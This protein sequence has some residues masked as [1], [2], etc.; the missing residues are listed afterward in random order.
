MSFKDFPL[1]LKSALIFSILPITIYS[2]YFL[3][4]ELEKAFS[5]FPSSA[6]NTEI[7]PSLSLWKYFAYFM[8]LFCIGA[9][10]GLALKKVFDKY[11]K[12]SSA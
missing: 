10:V 5:Q 9:I 4:I 7:F 2:I 11:L 12:S 6:L 1:W 3:I 8:L